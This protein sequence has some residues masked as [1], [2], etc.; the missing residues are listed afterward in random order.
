MPPRLCEVGAPRQIRPHDR[1]SM[2]AGQPAGGPK[3]RHIGDSHRGCL[4]CTFEFGNAV[5]DQWQR[6]LYAKASPARSCPRAARL[7]YSCTSAWLLVSRVVFAHIESSIDISRPLSL[8]GPV[9]PF[10]PFLI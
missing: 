8:R 2:P 5:V 4:A 7:S 6:A 10:N 9:A 3:R 1:L